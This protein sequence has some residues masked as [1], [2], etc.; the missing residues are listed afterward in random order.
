[1]QSINYQLHTKPKN[2]CVF[3][4]WQQ[5]DDFDGPSREAPSDFLTTAK[6]TI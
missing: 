3:T 2:P 4:S 1:M 6:L 5:A